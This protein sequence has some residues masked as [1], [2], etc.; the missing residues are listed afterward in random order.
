MEE[1]RQ[2]KIFHTNLNKFQKI[3]DAYFSS[4]KSMCSVKELYKQVMWKCR[5]L[6]MFEEIINKFKLEFRGRVLEMAGGYGVQASYLKSR[7]KSEIY[8]CYSDCSVTAVKMSGRFENFF[9]IEID[10]KWVSEAESIP[11]P[12]NSFDQIY[13]FAGFHH[14]QNPSKCI[15]EC[16]RVLKNNGKLYLILEPSSPRFLKNIFDKHTKRDEIIENS[17]TRHEYD[18][19]LKKNFSKFVRHNFTSYYNRESK[20]ALIYYLFLSL[21]PNWLV[22]LFPCSQV[23]IAEN[24]K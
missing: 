12:D 2:I 4:D 10:E 13:F 22:V 6:W 19:L 5:S 23:I 16:A 14:V 9:E 3:E 7:Y 1:K 8:L 11:A 18:M 15:A 17:F 20:R 21:L 24:K